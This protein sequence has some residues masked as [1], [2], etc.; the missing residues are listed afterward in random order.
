MIH[1]AIN[2]LLFV[3]FLAFALVIQFNHAEAAGPSGKAGKTIRFYIQA[4]Q[5][6]W[7]L[8]MADEVFAHLPTDLATVF[9]Y[10]TAGDGGKEEKYWQ[11]RES[12]AIASQTLLAD[13]ARGPGQSLSCGDIP[14][15]GHSLRRCGYGSTVAYFMRLPD[16]GC[17][18]DS[19]LSGQGFPRYNNQSLQNLKLQSCAAPPCL[20]AAVDGSTTYGSWEDLALTLAEII[21]FESSRA[22]ARRVSLNA[23]DFDAKRNPDDHSDHIHTGLAV[24]S[25]VEYLRSTPEFRKRSLRLSWYIHYDIQNRSRNVSPMGRMA[26]ASSFLAYDRKVWEAM[27]W[28]TLCNGYGFYSRSLESTHFRT[29]E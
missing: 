26:K 25:A 21:H 6:D 5:D 4:H 1:F 19:P 8:F 18:S 13:A 14:L 9:V 12:G 2:R 27:G 24:S 7:Q 3:I 11:A 29:E 28:S 17:C 15:R 22:G 23:P 16:G 10:M 20:L